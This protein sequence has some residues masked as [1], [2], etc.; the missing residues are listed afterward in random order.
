MEKTITTVT[1]SLPNKQGFIVSKDA[2]AG[3]ME[4][5]CFIGGATL[6]PEP[7]YP[8]IEILDTAKE[9]DIVYLDFATPGGY[10]GTGTLIANAIVHSAA[11]VVGTAI[12][13]TAS[14]GAVMLVACDTIKVGPLSTIMFHGSSG[15]SFGKTIDIEEEAKQMNQYFHGLLRSVGKR[16]LTD[17][18]LDEVLIQRIDKYLSAEEVYT[19]LNNVT[20]E[21]SSDNVEGEDTNE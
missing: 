8:L 12:S 17:A 7:W 18:Q 20:E 6:N 13:M 11:E 19:V 1:P 10:V 21:P 3:L 15:G 16:L 5:Y 9:G 2:G 4:Y 14:I